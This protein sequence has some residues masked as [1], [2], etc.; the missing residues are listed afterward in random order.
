MAQLPSGA[1][2]GAGASGVLGSWLRFYGPLPVARLC[3][4]LGIDPAGAELEELEE[5]LELLVASEKVVRGELL[6]PGVGSAA[7]VAAV[8]SL[9]TLLRWRRAA[10]RPSRDSLE[11]IPLSR[12]PRPA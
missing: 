2:G 3:E 1:V 8:S 11:A 9:E 6:E 12:L 7:E 10:A 4:L 5:V